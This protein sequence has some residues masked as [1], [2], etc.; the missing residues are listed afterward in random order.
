MLGGP[1]SP[2]CG[3]R[4]GRAATNPSDE[5]D[6]VPSGTWPSVTFSYTETPSQSEWFFFGSGPSSKEGGGATTQ[7]QQDWNNICNWYSRKSTTPAV[8]GGLTQGATELP[9]TDAII[10][11]YT[12]I[13]SNGARTVKAAYFWASSSVV[14]GS[15]ITSTGPAFGTTFGSVFAQ[16]SSNAG[17][18]N[19][20]ALFTGTDFTNENSTTGIVY[21]GAQFLDGTGNKGTIYGGATFKQNSGNSGVVNGGAL[22]ESGSNYFGLVNGGATFNNVAINRGTVNDGAT[23]NSSSQNFFGATVNGGATFN[24]SSRNSGS[25]FGGATFKSS[26][27]NDYYGNVA[28]GA[29]FQDAACSYRVE[30]RKF[31]AHVS[32]LPTCS[33]TAQTYLGSS[34][35]VI[36]GCG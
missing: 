7:E 23:F 1:C 6:W 12:P 28:G 2:C 36:C 25:V 20:G 33:G 13:N 18:I 35:S 17:T 3:T 10:H 22:F 32:E 15:S 9:S 8:G 5:G 26:A 14:S 31:T 19:G 30:N 24:N 11:V 27:F 4:C 29:T 21:G 16:R 34:A